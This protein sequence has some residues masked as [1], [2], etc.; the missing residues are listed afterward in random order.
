MINYGLSCLGEWGLS[1]LGEEVVFMNFTIKKKLDTFQFSMKRAHK[2]IL[3]LII[4]IGSVKTKY[5]LNVKG[6]V[7]E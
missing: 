3:V 2:A 7:S 4:P 6:M 1:C 5:S